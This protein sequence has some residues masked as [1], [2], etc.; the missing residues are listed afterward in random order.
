MGRG[1]G[2]SEQTY[3]PLLADKTWVLQCNGLIDWGSTVQ[4]FSCVGMGD[5]IDNLG[6]FRALA[7]KSACPRSRVL[8]RGPQG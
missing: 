5:G 1:K 6:R 7:R 2:V 8:E 4:R 3:I